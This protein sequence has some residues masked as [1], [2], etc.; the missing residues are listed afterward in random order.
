MGPVMI[1]TP[2]CPKGMIREAYDEDV[3]LA[4]WNS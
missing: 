2:D 1:T 3:P 4:N